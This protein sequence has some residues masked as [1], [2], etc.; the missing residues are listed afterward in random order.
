MKLS[1]EQIVEI[2]GRYSRRGVCFVHKGLG[3]TVRKIHND[4]EGKPSHVTGQQLCGGLAE[5][6]ADKW[7][8][9]AK[10]V[11][12]SFGIE[13]TRDFGEIVYLLIE[14][15]WMYAQPQDSI[16][17]FNDV[18]SFEKVLEKEFLFRN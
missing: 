5:C 17:D 10:V 18:Y 15:G 13:T 1:I 8:R 7:G 3:E 2:D 6:A 11:L 14:H 4:S 12:N 16:D 9:M